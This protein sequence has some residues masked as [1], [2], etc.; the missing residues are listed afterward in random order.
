MLQGAAS[1]SAAASSSA[2]AALE[3]HGSPCST[4]PAYLSALLTKFG[5][6][7]DEKLVP[8]RVIN[9][10]G[11]VVQYGTG[12]NMYRYGNTY[13]WGDGGRVLSFCR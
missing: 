6:D 12:D 9:H 10:G 8:Y 7:G 4:A 3:A 11:A 2:A 5:H 1:A 13:K